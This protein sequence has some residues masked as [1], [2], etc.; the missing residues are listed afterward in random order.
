MSIIQEALARMK[1]TIKNIINASEIEKRDPLRG[2]LKCPFCGGKTIDLI[3]ID[4]EK[5]K[6]SLACMNCTAIVW[7]KTIEECVKNWNQRAG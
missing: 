1:N 7:G 3:F 6:A 2:L 4:D 5:A